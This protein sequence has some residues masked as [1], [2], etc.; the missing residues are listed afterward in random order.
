MLLALNAF[1]TFLFFSKIPC[2]NT[3]GKDFYNLSFKLDYIIPQ[4]AEFSAHKS[5][6]YSQS[7]RIWKLQTID[8]THTIPLHRPL[9]PCSAMGNVLIFIYFHHNFLLLGFPNDRYIA[10][11][12]Y[13][14]SQIS[15]SWN[16]ITML[17]YHLSSLV[18]NCLSFLTNSP[19][20]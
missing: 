17:G 5:L 11:L 13:S 9:R 8:K 14:G 12:S 3:S 6:T 16:C 2:F 10:L 19:T 7:L 1:K 4:L 18:S 20:H 15:R